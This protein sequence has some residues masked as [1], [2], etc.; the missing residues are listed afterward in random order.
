MKPEIEDM[1][2]ALQGEKV[3]FYQAKVVIDSIEE[4]SAEEKREALR[5]FIPVDKVPPPAPA[6]KVP[7]PAPANDVSPPAPPVTIKHSQLKCPRCGSDEH[8]QAFRTIYES[9]TSTTSVTR[10][11]VVSAG[12]HVAFGG[13]GGGG[14]Q[15]TLSAQGCSPPKHP[16]RSFFGSIISPRFCIIA[17]ILLSCFL[18]ANDDSSLWKAMGIAAIWAAVYLNFHFIRPHLLAKYNEKLASWNRSYYCHRCG[19]SFEWSPKSANRES[20]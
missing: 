18:A 11:A 15:Q 17:S 3:S 5:R 7:P 14:T 20:W 1:I 2:Q 13:G 9:G 12:R 8:V 6:D 10:F 4:L 16:E 19:H